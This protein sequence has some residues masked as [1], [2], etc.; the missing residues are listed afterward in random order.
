MNEELNVLIEVE[1]HQETVQMV[2]EFVALVS[3]FVREINFT[4]FKSPKVFGDF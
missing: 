1:R 2:M 4:I 3:I